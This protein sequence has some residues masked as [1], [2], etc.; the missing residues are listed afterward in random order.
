LVE[1]NG[2]VVDET[3]K[4]TTNF[5]VLADPNSTSSKAQKARKQGT[6][7]ISEEDF[8]KMCGV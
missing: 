3:M 7:L 2:G 8:I 4:K 1:K 5:L 6:T